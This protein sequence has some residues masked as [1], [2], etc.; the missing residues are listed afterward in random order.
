MVNPVDVV[1]AQNGTARWKTLA[2]AGVSQ[3]QL[4]KALER[5]LL[6]RV[7]RGLY[8]L[9]TTNAH[10]VV[11]RRAGADSACLTAAEERGFWVLRRPSLPH[12][13]ANHG[14]H[15]PGVVKHRAVLPLSDEDVVS[16][17]LR[18]ADELD[19]LVVLTSAVRQKRTSITRLRRRFHRK[20]DS[21]IRGILNRVDPHAESALEVAS[22]FHLENAGFAVSSQV[23][24]K[25]VGRMDQCV[26]GCLALE[27]MGKEFHLPESAFNEDMRRLNGYTVESFPVLR[28]GY[29]QVVHR[30]HEFVA[31]IHKALAAIQM[32]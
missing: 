23:Y 13:A 2:L 22:R 32:S 21:R 31:L 8:C 29:A 3:T 30:P 26:D 6:T 24:L 16:Q 11:A 20:R 7:S 15:I 12:V 4:K 19:A 14:R 18:C 1:K 17:V 10:R 5:R 25:G 28:V 27:L 9:P